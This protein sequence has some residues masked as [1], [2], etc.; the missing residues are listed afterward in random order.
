M[1]APAT[2]TVFV[3]ATKQGQID[4]FDD[5]R[6]GQL[7]GAFRGRLKERDLYVRSTLFF[8]TRAQLDAFV[9]DPA[10]ENDFL[11]SGDCL[12]PKDTDAVFDGA[13][14]L[15][16]LPAPSAVMGQFA[17]LSRGFAASL[18]SR[19]PS[20]ITPPSQSPL[21][22]RVLFVSF[23]AVGGAGAAARDTALFE[24]SKLE[25]VHGLRS[26]CD[27]MNPFLASHHS[28]S[29][30]IHSPPGSVRFPATEPD[31]RKFKKAVA[32]HY[33]LTSANK[34]MLFNMLGEEQAKGEVILAHIWPR[35]YTNWGDP[36]EHLGMPKDFHMNPRG[37][38]LLPKEVEKAFDSGVLILVPSPPAGAAGSRAITIH[39]IRPDAASEY[40]K[41]LDGRQLY[42]P[43]G[44]PFCRLLAFF[45]LQAKKQV[46]MCAEHVNAAVRIAESNATDS[47][48][49]RRMLS[50]F[51]EKLRRVRCL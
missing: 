32:A 39:V 10:A 37:F 38:L 5:V 27:R 14:L 19:L 33:G 15:L 13:S 4:V 34:G 8:A 25:E 17:S 41:A 1:A 42:I 16:V 30:S 36:C 49:G 24:S 21:A 47:L 48:S 28:D 22:S 44:L 7:W 31:R 11:A 46:A 26:L 18:A 45:A 6:V 29:I 51:V 20:L 43:Q 35:S 3:K 50:D 23:S 2:V 12:R 40:V 9:E